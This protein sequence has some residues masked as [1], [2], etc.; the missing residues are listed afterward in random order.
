M[1]DYLPLA[2]LALL[3]GFKHS[4]D[5]DHLL[6]VANFL[7]KAH[8]LSMAARISASWAIGHMV[9]AAI[10]TTVLFIFRE[11]VLQHFL[12]SFEKIVAIMLILL[13]SWSL[14]DLLHSHRH[15]HAGSEHEHPHIHNNGNGH[16]H[17]HMLGIGIIHGLA[18]NDELLILFTATLGVASLPQILAGVAVF[19]LGVVLGMVA[20]ATLFSLPLLKARSN[21]L[22]K[23]VTLATGTASVAYGLLMA[24]KA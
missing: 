23:G 24:I 1:L 7:R 11:S 13:G 19:S 22:Y 14:K 5:A 2:G 4:Y 12:N 9:T 18:S 3:L 15:S 10:V 20:F 6:A 16:V 8:N 21:A 17:K